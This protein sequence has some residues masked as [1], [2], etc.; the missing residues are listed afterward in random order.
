M[1]LLQSVVGISKASRSVNWLV[2]FVRFNSSSQNRWINR[3]RSDLYTKK[4]KLQG[5]KSRAAFK[6][7]EIDD[8]FHLFKQNEAQNVLDLGF[9]PGAWS[10]VAYDRTKPNGTVL[11][12]D[13][14]PCQPPKGISSIQANILSKKTH[15]LIRMFFSPPNEINKHNTLN[16][17]YDQFQH[18]PEERKL[19]KSINNPVNDSFSKSLTSIEKFPLDVIISDMYEPCSQ[20]TG[21]WNNFTNKIYNR[22][23][24]TTGVAIKDHYMSMDLC[25]AALI[26]AV[27]LLKPGGS[28]TCK[29]YTGKEDKLLEYR[30]KKVFKK[31]YRFKPNSSRGESKEL[32]FVGIDKFKNVDKLKVFLE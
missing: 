22:M 2:L 6:L 26:V 25:D 4:A 30:L 28:F 24:N 27:N 19:N 16:Q 23:A 8:K 20:T 7:I 5:F 31:V 32:Y 11:G 21:F 29:L 3:Q 12:V 10:Q 13:I 14:L 1:Y 15:E 18:I 17:E 9:A